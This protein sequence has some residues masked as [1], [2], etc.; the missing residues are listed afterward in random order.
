M[1]HIIKKS[2]SKLKKVGL[3]GFVILAAK[4][5]LGIDKLEEQVST[6]QYFLNLFHSP[7]EIPVTDDK[8]LRL[9][10]L[11]DAELIH[12]LDKFFVKHNITYWLDFGT[13]LGAVRHK[14]FIPWDDDMDIAVPRADYIKLTTELR[15]EL[16]SYG[17]TLYDNKQW[18]GVGYKHHETGIWCDLFAIDSYK[19][20]E[21]IDIAYINVR[22]GIDKLKHKGID[23]KGLP[24]TSVV[25][26][27]EDVL[28]SIE[29]GKNTVLYHMPEN[30]FPSYGT[31]AMYPTEVVY[32][33]TKVSFESYE[34]NAPYDTDAY[35][36]K[37]YS[38][39]YMQFPGGG[40]TSSWLSNRSTTSKSVG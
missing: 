37:M 31:Y 9:L 12:I 24:V 38:T 25:N 7:S 39:H 32:P 13:L 33:I 20:D 15:S 8:D 18:F 23:I 28:P 3:G 21:D 22:K 14:G 26:A 6:L 40:G 36:S 11:C 29:N 16:E 2:I 17:L 27:I 30:T 4:K 5:V 1:V 35:L 19:T 34:V 10:Q